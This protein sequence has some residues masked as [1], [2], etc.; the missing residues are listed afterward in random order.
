MK[1]IVAVIMVIGIGTAVFAAQQKKA[2]QVAVVSPT[3]VASIA[4]AVHYMAHFA[5]FTNSTF[6]DFNNERYHQQSTDVYLKADNP[7]EVHVNAHGITWQK[8]F[9][10]L[11]MKLTKSC[12]TT[13]TGQEFCTSEN[14]ELTFFI[15]G[16]QNQ[17]VLDEIISPNSKLLVSFGIK[18]KSVESELEK[19]EEISSK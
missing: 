19:L 18:D 7:N 2:I 4:P 12:L 8:F 11:P 14:S 6:R 16:E 9:D 1:F 13:G 5:I 10:T 15:N 17:N 3:P